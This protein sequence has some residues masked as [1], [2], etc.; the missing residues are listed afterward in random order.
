MR[1]RRP[2]RRAVPMAAAAVLLGAAAAASLSCARKTPG[3]APVT[4]RYMRWTDPAELAA[5]RTLLETFQKQHPAITVTLEF[6][7][8]DQYWSNCRRWWRPATPP[9]SS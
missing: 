8:W 7:S 4:I 2:G 3:A 6:N 9:T 5:T 1:I